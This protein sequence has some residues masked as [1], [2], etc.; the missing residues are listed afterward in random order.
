MKKFIVKTLIYFIP[1]CCLYFGYMIM[2]QRFAGDIGRLI[3]LPFKKYDQYA[4]YA[5]AATLQENFVVD[6]L[7]WSYDK[8]R[9]DDLI[10]IMT[11]GD[12]FSGHLGLMGYQNYLAHLLDNRII[13]YRFKIGDNQL[14]TAVSLL[15]SGIIDST[16]CRIL[17][18]Q[19]VGRFTIEN[20]CGIDFESFYELPQNFKKFQINKEKIKD[21][22]LF[23]LCSFIRL[24]L[25]YKNPVDNRNLKQLC[26]THLF[27][28]RKLYYYYE[29]DMHF[30]KLTKA[31][32]DKAQENL[33]RLNRHFSEKGIKMIFLIAAD[34]YDVY[35]PFL[36]DDSLPVDTTKEGLSKIPDV[37]VVDTKPLFQE[38]IRN[39]EKDV[40]MLHDTHWSYK[41]SEAVARELLKYLQ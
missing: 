23:S 8:F 7:A 28:S 27:L 25:N 5:R 12:S 18:L 26:F 34:K 22:N 24:R 17:I 21:I 41:A 38:M 20:L 36:K 35:R 16:N 32:I 9:N 11:I 37:C 33:I 6:T 40:Y 3:K 29:G 39:G 15:N 13:N 1:F 30:Q 14:N 19:N 31:D 4:G 10:K 2:S